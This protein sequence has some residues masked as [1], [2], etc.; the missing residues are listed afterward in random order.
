MHAFKH[1][2]TSLQ[3]IAYTHTLKPPW[4]YVNIQFPRATYTYQYTVSAVSITH[5]PPC[6]PAPIHTHTQTGRSHP[7]CIMQAYIISCRLCTVLT[8]SRQDVLKI[9]YD[10]SG[11]CVWFLLWCKTNQS[12]P[13]QISHFTHTRISLYSAKIGYFSKE[14]QQLEF[15]CSFADARSRVS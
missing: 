11:G 13:A 15:F 14:A 1:T 2:N 9:S 8:L 12:F 10:V 7:M 4:R 6:R 3:T 5:T